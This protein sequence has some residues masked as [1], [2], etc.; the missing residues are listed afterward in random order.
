MTRDERNELVCAERDDLL[1]FLFMSVFLLVANRRRS[2]LV[3]QSFKT[4]PQANLPPIS[5]NKASAELLDVNTRLLH[6][7]FLSFDFVA[8]LDLDVFAS[9]II[10]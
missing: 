6:G 1:A 2:Q 4:T 3:E 5:Q 8:G 9:S 7:R 10:K